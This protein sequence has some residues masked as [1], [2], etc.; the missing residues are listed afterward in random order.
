ML[1][2]GLVD[3]NL[4]L[5]NFAGYM[6]EDFDHRADSG[7][8]EVDFDH[9]EVDFVDKEVDFDHKVVDRIQVTF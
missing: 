7:D 9:K 1:V 8:K 6:E 2:G 4:E 5:H 3:H